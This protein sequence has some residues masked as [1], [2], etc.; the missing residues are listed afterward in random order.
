MR[1]FSVYGTSTP[2]AEFV[3]TVNGIRCFSHGT[4][5][6]SFN[7]S[8]KLH[9]KVEVTIAVATGSVTVGTTI[10]QY[11][12][13]ING[14]S[15]YVHFE[16]PIRCPYVDNLGNELGSITLNSGD[17]ITYNHITFNGPDYWEVDMVDVDAYPG[18]DLDVG[19]IVDRVSNFMRPIFSYDPLPNSAKNIEDLMLLKSRIF[20]KLV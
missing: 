4:E 19:N 8:H 20:P 16:Q 17:T 12:A 15:G 7:T 9:G 3:V 5:L 13:V 14:V 11:P 2:D 1:T 18:L 10:V 6:F